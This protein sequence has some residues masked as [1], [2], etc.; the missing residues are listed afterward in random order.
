[1]D[2]CVIR[3]FLFVYEKWT[4]GKNDGKRKRKRKTQHLRNSFRNHI[5]SC[6]ALHKPFFVSDFL[7][8]QFSIN[9]LCASFGPQSS[10]I[11]AK[12]MARCNKNSFIICIAYVWATIYRAI[13][14]VSQ[15][16]KLVVG[17][18]QKKKTDV[19]C[20]ST[21]LLIHINIFVWNV[22]CDINKCRRWNNPLPCKAL[23]RLL[24]ISC[25]R[26]SIGVELDL[27]L[28]LMCMCI[29]DNL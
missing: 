22:P 7:Y 27:E 4:N 23:I 25:V 15:H 9:I 20:R 5:T 26:E 3:F 13:V 29:Y 10:G 6:A 8:F 24:H 12:T 2:S 19:K 16:I 18:C 11:S 17:K 1:M 14:Y 28:E 21:R